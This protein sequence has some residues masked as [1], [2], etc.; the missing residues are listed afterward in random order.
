MG[1]L[2]N[3]VMKEL[4]LTLG[5]LGCAFGTDYF[6]PSDGYSVFDISFL[7]CSLNIGF[8]GRNRTFSKKGKSFFTWRSTGE[9]HL[10]SAHSLG[11]NKWRGGLQHDSSTMEVLRTSTKGDSHRCFFFGRLF[12]LASTPLRKI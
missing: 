8:T 11:T 7:A 5:T 2:G 9:K 3:V 6:S 12:H 10:M 4:A 1:M